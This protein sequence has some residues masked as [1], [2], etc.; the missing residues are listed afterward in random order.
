MMEELQRHGYQV[1]PGT[2]Y[3]ILHSLE[4]E[5]FLKSQ[6]NNVEGKI[7]KYYSITPAGE[8]ILRK[9]IEKL[10]ELTSEVMNQVF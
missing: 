7:R 3:P 5:G 10:K 6:K 9:A 8:E 2:L 4:K 1:S